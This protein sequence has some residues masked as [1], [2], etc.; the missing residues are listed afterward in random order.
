MRTFLILSPLL[1][2]ASSCGDDQTCEA[3]FHVGEDG[4]CYPGSVDTGDADTDSDS[5][6]DSDTDSDT[7]TDNGED[8]TDTLPTDPIRPCG[9]DPPPEEY[10]LTSADISGEN[11]TL[12][13]RYT[14]GERVHY[15]S[16]CWTEEF[17]ESNPPEITARVLH[18]GGED[19]GNTVFEEDISFNL[20][21]ILDEYM[22][23][24][25]STG[26]FVVN[27]DD[28]SATYSF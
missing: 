17:S 25:G 26:S 3:G 20:V 23:L 16:V 28:L 6:S 15:F 2:F 18:D 21:L 5:D 14:G 24:Y 13:F 7:D 27:I 1:L 22:G 8:D 11:L 19:P 12:G 4:N 9:D 10:V